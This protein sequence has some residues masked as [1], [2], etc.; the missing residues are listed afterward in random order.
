MD[1]DVCGRLHHPQRLPFLCPVDGRNRCY[2]GRIKL[3]LAHL[4][5]E[6]LQK[7]IE[8]LVKPA[9]DDDSGRPHG[10]P[11][12]RGVA[13]KMSLSEQH[14]AQDRTSRIIEQAEKLREE[15]ARAR[16]DI[17]DRKAA[18]ARRKADL[19]SASAGLEARRAR[20]IEETQRSIHA[21]KFKW[22]R[23]ADALAR[24]RAFL[25]MEAAKLYGL[26]RSKRTGS[27]TKYEYR[28]G[29][30]EIV[31]LESIQSVSPEQLSTSLANVAHIVSLASHYLSIRLPAELTLPHR[32]YPR[33]TVFTLSSS[34]GHEPV[35]FPGSL[36]FSAETRDTTKHHPKPR[37]LFVDKPLATLAKE[38]PAMY[39]LFLEGV[40]HLAY[41]VA[42]LCTSQGVS[43]GDKFSFDDVC[44]MGRNLYN[45]LIAQNHAAQAA[46][47]FAANE[48]QDPGDVPNVTTLMGRYSHGSAHS[49]LA[50]S[51]GAEFVR[52][53]KLL[54][55]VKVA[56]KLKK[57]L[58]SEVAIPEWEVLEEDEWA[59]IGQDEPVVEQGKSKSPNQDVASEQRSG[60]SGT[61][62]W[63]K[64]KSR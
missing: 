21:T 34:Y 30:V 45:L 2:D 61:N 50:G 56:D 14:V 36:H 1:C 37:P 12:D 25:C 47:V 23:N 60:P 8:K 24:T 44:R 16:K 42:W 15:V 9:P 58:Q 63:T 17:Q 33:P 49:F 32:D 28:L 10:L 35:P 13:T 4:E 46:K 39:S 31:D 26:R 57:K 54:S 53:F 43:V 6:G 48:N 62:G 3:A 29:G 38:D 5:N 55:P 52:N 22:D 7:Q 18:I 27:S 51:E 19:A 11:Q 20:I 64:V 41:N 40:T 59:G